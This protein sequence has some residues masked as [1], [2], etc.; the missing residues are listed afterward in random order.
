ML[1]GTTPASAEEDAPVPTARY[2]ESPQKAVETITELLMKERFGELAS[3]YD[4]T[5][6]GIARSELESGAFFVRKKRPPVAQPAG[7]WRYK[8]PFTSAR[9]SP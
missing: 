2:F 5:G 8:H 1:I 9:A 7:F 4:L 3:Y 6:S